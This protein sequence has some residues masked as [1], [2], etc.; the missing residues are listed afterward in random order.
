[1]DVDTEERQHGNRR[2]AYREWPKMG[3]GNKDSN[4]MKEERDS[5]FR[6]RWVAKNR[7]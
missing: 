7:P 2:D 4:H 1:V 6:F 5:Q 3:V